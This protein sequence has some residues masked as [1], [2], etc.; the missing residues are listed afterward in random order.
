MTDA[1]VDVTARNAPDRYAVE[2]DAGRHRLRAD[3]PVAAGGGDAGPNPFAL[4]LSGLG[5]CTAITLRMYAERKGWP[6]ENVTVHCRH[7]RDGDTDQIERE[8]HIAGPLDDTQRT[9]L[10][11]IAEK[12]PVT[13]L[14]KAGAE[15]R[16]MVR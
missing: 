10:M 16:T 12:T 14:V 11:E 15:I 6:L 3:E 2:V 8:L 5:A 9:R 1:A 4:V 7:H 13:K